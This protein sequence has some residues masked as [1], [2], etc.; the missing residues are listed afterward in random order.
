MLI[1]S[2]LALVQ[3]E[4]LEDANNKR[5]KITERYIERLDGNPRIASP[6]RC[7][8][9]GKPNYHIMPVL[10]SKSVDRNQV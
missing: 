5:K 6:Y 1:S 7:F 9:R 4:K 10:L 8:P 2:A 3:L